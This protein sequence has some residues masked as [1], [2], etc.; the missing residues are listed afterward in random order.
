MPTITNS[1][2]TSL[3]DHRSR[4]QLQSFVSSYAADSCDSKM[5]SVPYDGDDVVIPV[6]TI[7]AGHFPKPTLIQIDNEALTDSMQITVN[8]IVVLPFAGK[9]TIMNPSTSSIDPVTATVVVG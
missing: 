1:L 2:K 5:V 6:K 9:I 4:R 8:G 3:T 7:F